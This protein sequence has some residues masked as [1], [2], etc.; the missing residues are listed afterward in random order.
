MLYML[1]H[2]IAIANVAAYRTFVGQG[3]DALFNVTVT[4]QGDI[5]ETFNFTVYANDT[6]IETH[7]VTYLLSGLNR[8]TTFTWNTT[9]L[10]YGNY[11]ISTVASPV[12]VETDTADNNYTCWVIITLVGDITGQGGSPDWNVDMK[13]VS[14]VARRLA[15]AVGL[16]RRRQQR[17]QSRHERHQYCSQALRRTHLDILEHKKIRKRKK[18]GVAGDFAILEFLFMKVS[19]LAM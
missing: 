2:D 6:A 18:R 1:R 17:R 7:T 11:T 5:P 3:F 16:E 9:G 13:D 15:R 14:Y 10:A 19:T 8:S 4:N 12:P